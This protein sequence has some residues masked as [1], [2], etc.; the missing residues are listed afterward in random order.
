MCLFE[1]CA[2]ANAFEETIVTKRRK[3]K[4]RPGGKRESRSNRADPESPRSL[5]VTVGWM[6]A[7][8]ATA[9]ALVVA[10]VTASLHSILPGGMFLAVSRYLLLTAVITGT[11][12]LALIP[13]VRRARDDR[14]PQAVEWTAIGIG[15]LPWLWLIWLLL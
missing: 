10:A 2:R 5:A 4:K 1:R 3:R 13:V 9:L 15:L 12:T 6:L 8:L 7:T 11:V 14:P